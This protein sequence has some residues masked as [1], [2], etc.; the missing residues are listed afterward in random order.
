MIE[1]ADMFPSEEAAVEWFEGVV[2]PDERCCGHCGSRRN[3]EASHKTMPYWC[4]DCRSYFSART[5][6]FMERSKISVRKWVYAICL[7]LTSLKG[8]AATELHRDLGISYRAAWFL[9]RRIRGAIVAEDLVGTIAIVGAEDRDI[10]R[11]V[12]K[13]I[14]K[15]ATKGGGAPIHKALRSRAGPVSAKSSAPDYPA[16]GAPRDGV[17][18]REAAA[19]PGPDIRQRPVAGGGLNAVRKRRTGTPNAVLR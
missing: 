5:G 1:L 18:G 11:V 14:A 16:N 13:V 3:T 12:A 9:R 2:W 15:A 10:R 17:V 6:T 19:L 8:V 4:S 7:E